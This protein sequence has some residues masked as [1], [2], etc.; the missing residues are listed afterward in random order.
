MAGLEHEFSED[1]RKAIAVNSLKVA[2]VG[3]KAVNDVTDLKCKLRLAACKTG[4]HTFVIK[5][6]VGEFQMTPKQI[7]REIEMV[8]EVERQSK[9]ILQFEGRDTIS[10]LDRFYQAAGLG[11]L[12]DPESES[13]NRLFGHSV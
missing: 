2:G 6:P 12:F 5:T 13:F 11:S 3:E 7:G 9:I 8:E 1:E 4:G 10:E